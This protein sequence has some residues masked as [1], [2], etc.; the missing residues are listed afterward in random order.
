MWGY[1][2]N[3]FNNLSPYRKMD[4]PLAFNQYFRN[5]LN[6]CD[7]YIG[8]SYALQQFTK[9]HNWEPNDVDI[10][11][12]CEDIHN[13]NDK[14]KLFET[15]MNVKLLKSYNYYKSK[16][17]DN[18]NKIFTNKYDEYNEKFHDSILST[19]TYELDGFN[20]K[21]Q[22][23]AI[24][25]IHPNNI[26]NVLNSI[27]DIPACVTYKYLDNGDKIFYVPE[28]GLDAL[29]T[30]VIASDKICESRRDKYMKRGYIFLELI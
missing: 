18:I 30:K 20:K 23:I 6:K 13:F 2:S 1:M 29:Y 25:T 10:M 7:G 3:I 15:E 16:Q 9:A 28:K 14:V 8:G 26:M 12:G 21:I 5:G 11:I 22:L 19:R 4:D 17:Y 27:T 24:K